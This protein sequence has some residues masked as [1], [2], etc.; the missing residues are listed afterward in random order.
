[1]YIN[2]GGTINSS[3]YTWVY[4][5]NTGAKPLGDTTQ[6]TG[7]YVW[8]KP[9][10][11][12]MVYIRCTGPGG[13]GTGGGTIT[14][15]A[16]SVSSGAG[17]GAGGV[18]SQL[19]FASSLPEVLYIQPGRG[20]AGGASN[21]SNDSIGLGGGNGDRANITA[22]P[23]LVS[24]DPSSDNCFLAS[25]AVGAAGGVDATAGA[26]STAISITNNCLLAAL[27]L[28]KS[29]AD[30]NRAGAGGAGAS[31]S[32]GVSRVMLT[33]TNSVHCHGG[34]G[35]AGRAIGLSTTYPGGEVQVDSG[36]VLYGPG[37]EILP[38]DPAPGVDV[39]GKRGSDGYTQH[40]KVPGTNTPGSGGSSSSNANAGHGG[41]GGIGCGGAGGGSVNNNAGT[42]YYSGRGG[43]G[44]AGR[45]IITAW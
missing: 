30:L 11:V 40:P 4:D 43:A 41:S 34:A 22:V 15:Q 28:F 35:G 3:S 13:G 26:G 21:N 7:C 36:N 44:G 19:F 12:T 31:I 17:G 2:S 5:G 9:P 29:N 37:T 25:G 39:S 14:G 23:P 32:A 6:P 1:M 38:G 24:A 10:G 27:G 33:A 45:V 8:I 42:T 18:S 16:S 20:G